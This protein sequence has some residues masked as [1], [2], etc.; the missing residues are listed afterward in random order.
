M[1]VRRFD[2][3]QAPVLMFGLSAP[4]GQPDLAEFRRLARRQVAPGLEQLPGGAEVRITGGREQEVRVQLDRYRM[5]AYGIT[6]AAIEARLIDENVDISAGTLEE[7]AEVLLFEVFHDFELPT[8][9][10]GKFLRTS[11]ALME[12][13]RRGACP[14]S[15]PWHWSIA[16]SIIWCA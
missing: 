1:L 16:K 8:M 13:A 6:L 12:R 14:M 15:G 2:P 9:F 11:H 10:V 3:R 4:S 5:E 7:G